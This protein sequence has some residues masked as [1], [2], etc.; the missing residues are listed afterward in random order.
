MKLALLLVVACAGVARAD[1]DPPK[2]PPPFRLSVGAGTSFLLFGQADAPRLRLDGHLDVMPGGRWGRWGVATALRH[3]VIDPVADD[4]IV[5]AGV[6]YEAAA[7]R[8]RLVLA[9]HG[10]LGW[11]LAG[12]PV[13]G[14]GVE[15]TLWLVPKKLGPLAIVFDVTA[16]LVVDGTDATRL[17]I[18]SATR[19][20]FAR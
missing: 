20:S 10:D 3:V 19:L 8:P 17:V 5:T 6:R 1:D 7:S 15:T 12:A 9:L 14:G 13:I 11:E 2:P 16:H 18:G 4:A